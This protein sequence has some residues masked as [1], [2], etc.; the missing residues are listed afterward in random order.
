MQIFLIVLVCFSSTVDSYERSSS[1]QKNEFTKYLKELKGNV[2]EFNS[3]PVLKQYEAISG[4]NAGYGF[5]APNV[6]SAYIL[7]VS[8]YDKKDKDNIK[9]FF[10]PPFKTR[11]GLNRYH[12]LLGYFQDRLTILENK[13]NKKKAEEFKESDKYGEYLDI[14]IKSIGRYYYK[15]Y[16]SDQYFVECTLYLYHYPLLRESILQKKEPVLIQLLNVNVNPLKK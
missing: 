14:F 3:I 12:T 6:A 16:N 2:V 8:V 13:L 7:K 9:V 4:I 15:E 1:Y 11:E 10:Y 5:F